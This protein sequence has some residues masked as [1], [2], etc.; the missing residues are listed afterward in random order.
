[1]SSSTS[2]SPPLRRTGAFE[3]QPLP[4]RDGLADRHCI[5]IRNNLAVALYDSGAEKQ[6]GGDDA[7]AT[8][9][10]QVALL[11]LEKVVKAAGTD[12]RTQNNLGVVKLAL[13][14]ED[15]AALTCFKKAL[16]A[17]PDHAPAASNKAQM[18]GYNEA[19]ALQLDR[20]GAASAMDDSRG[21]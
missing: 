21:K 9:C 15:E 8:R 12:A 10:F 19:T 7:E 5:S 13:D 14:K 2:P 18:Q 20:T 1:M 17:D 16:E 6:K 3:L 11:Q 4:L